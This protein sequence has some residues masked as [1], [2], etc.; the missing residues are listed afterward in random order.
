MERE[1]DGAL[2]HECG[3][4]FLADGDAEGGALEGLD[5]DVY[6]C[7]VAS[8]VGVWGSIG[9]QWGCGATRRCRGRGEGSAC[10]GIHE[11]LEGPQRGLGVRAC[12]RRV[13]LFVVPEDHSGREEVLVPDV[14]GVLGELDEVGDAC[15]VVFYGCLGGEVVQWD[16]VILDYPCG[17]LVAG[18][19]GEVARGGSEYGV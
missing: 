8:G 15:V 12:E 10:L 7:A 18:D 13:E 5:L 14:L 1:A 4:Y 2:G 3:G 17:G 9:R 16:A 11:D 6:W 19:A